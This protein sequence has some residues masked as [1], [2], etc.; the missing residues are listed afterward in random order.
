MNGPSTTKLTSKAFV[1]PP[2]A[3][4]AAHSN[5][6]IPSRASHQDPV[7]Q[8]KA[9]SSPV[10]T[11]CQKHEYL[12]DETLFSHTHAPDPAIPARADILEYHRLLFPKRSTPIKQEES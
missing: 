4:V 12:F 5:L 6:A 8:P 7:E 9:S 2:S 11:D 1:A 10:E 3:P